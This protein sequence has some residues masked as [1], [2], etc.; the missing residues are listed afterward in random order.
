MK[1][2]VKSTDKSLRIKAEE[3][4]NKKAKGTKNQL[5]EIET[6]KLIHELEV[7]Q[8]ELELQKEELNQAKEQAEELVAKYTELYDFA[9]SGYFTLS[10]EG[11]IIGL[12]LRGANILGKVR[13]H[14]INAKFNFFVSEDTKPIFNKFL[15]EIFRSK[16]KESCELVIIGKDKTPIYVHLNGSITKNKDQC[17]LTG[18][19]INKLKQAEDELLI[20]KE[21]A[22]ES[23]TLKTSFLQNMSHEIRTPLNAIMGFAG[24]LEEAFGNKDKLGRFALIINQRSRDLLEI[25]NDIL[26]ISKI[27]SG[28]VE[29]R[30]EEC[31]LSD[32]FSE[33]SSFFGEYQERLGK[34][35]LSFKMQMHCKSIDNLIVTDVGKLK[36]IFINLIS[37]AFKFTDDGEIDA[38]C[39]YDANQNFIFYVSD[40]G[41]GIP[42]DKKTLVFERFTQ[43][44]QNI[45]QNIGGT[46]LGLS[47]VNGLINILGGEINLESEAGKGS[48][49]SFS[50]PYK[51]IRPLHHEPKVIEKKNDY[52]FDNKT[53]L[54][55]EDDLHSA[56]Y[57]DEILED[58][59]LKIIH[60]LR[61]LEAIQK[62]ISQSVDLVLMDV[63]LPDVNGYEATRQIQQIK[64][65]LKIIAQTAF[66]SHDEKQKALD[67]GCTDYVS[68]PINQHLL[69]AMLDKHLMINTK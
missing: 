24:L 37:N 54:I 51:K 33:L 66:A 19:D 20:A 41:I 8:I 45:N 26:D 36:Q 29:L 4:L 52:R 30:M 21:K 58:T 25:I 1:E 57:F 67:A 12:N 31:N 53:I 62:A 49:F 46:G 16:K 48:T 18:I 60:S 6:L 32:L 23:N 17:L 63:Q 69:L 14:L 50:I 39:K 11:E 56:E 64:P 42:A 13:S 38:G 40:T 2:T 43:L 55:V 61:G 28:R 34:Q 27:E 9:P 44:K 68:K 47:I 15:D 35:H 3:Y 10:K 22:E 59:G 5:S 65:H 7:H